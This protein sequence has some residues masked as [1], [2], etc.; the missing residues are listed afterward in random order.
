MIIDCHCHAG[1]GDGLTG[2]WDSNAGL[3]RYLRRAGAAGIDRTALLAAFHSDYARA[4]AGVARIV[5]SRPKQFYAFAFVHAVRD[6]G[7]IAAMVKTA[8]EQYGFIGIKLHRHDARITG[9]VCEAA[10]VFGVPVLYDPVGEVA[11]AELLAAQYPDVDFILPHLGSFADDWAAQLALIDHLVRHKNIYT[12][13]AG[14]RRF[15]LLEQAVRR[16]GPH[17]VLFGSDGPWLHPA[18]ELEK[19]RLLR[20][21]EGDERLILGGNFLRLIRRVA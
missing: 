14:V 3:G 10:R 7:R 17:K 13:S 8:V 2:P 15:D 6:R 5:A 9:E 18:L 19:I 21:P 11:V 1:P 4:N 20:L 16:A 12:D